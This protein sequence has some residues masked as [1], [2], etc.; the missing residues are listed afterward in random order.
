M[1]YIIKCTVRLLN[2]SYIIII[3]LN[4]STLLLLMYFVTPPTL[5]SPY[6]QILN[7]MVLN[8]LQII[9]VLHYVHSLLHLQIFW[10]GCCI[11]YIRCEMKD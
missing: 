9:L 11:S 3:F 5:I 4:D 6:C 7:A 10:H 8:G 2:K 1:M